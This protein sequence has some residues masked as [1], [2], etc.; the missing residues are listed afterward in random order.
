MNKASLMEETEFY[1]FQNTTQ[2]QIIINDLPQAASLKPGQV[3]RSFTREEVMRSSDLRKYTQAGL[4]VQVTEPAWA[5]TPKR[6]TINQP[7]SAARPPVNLQRRVPE[8][9]DVHQSGDRTSYVTSKGTDF[10]PNA[11]FL[12]G[13]YVVIVGPN[14]FKGTLVRQEAK[15]QNRWLVQLEDSRNVYVAQENLVQYENAVSG[16][17]ASHMEEAPRTLM[18]SDVIKR[19]IVKPERAFQESGTMHAGQVLNNRTAKPASALQGRPAAEEG[20]SVTGK[21]FKA[22]EVTAR[23]PSQPGVQIVTADANVIDSAK[24]LAER[25]QRLANPPDVDEEETGTIIV[26]ASKMGN[27]LEAVETNPIKIAHDTVKSFGHEMNRQSKKQAA[28]NARRAARRAAQVQPEQT[29]A[30][31]L[32]GAPDAVA[33]FFNSTPQQQK[34]GIS[35]MSDPEKLQS[36]FDWSQDNSTKSMIEQRLTELAS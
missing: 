21:R 3:S 29:L 34:F 8:G 12:P 26:A 31:A 1:W 6:N 19:G 14:R 25:Q 4:L 7:T 2:T 9:I 22:S 27:P 17:D 32:K 13:D 35:R 11:E 15:M 23:K 20:V 18:A 5:V 30:P 36:L 24:I 33:K 16:G 28:R 10:R